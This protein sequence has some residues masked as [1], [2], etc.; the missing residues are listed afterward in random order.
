MLEVRYR[1]QRLL[2]LEWLQKFI[3]NRKEKEKIQEKLK[4]AYKF[5]EMKNCIGKWSIFLPITSWWV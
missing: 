2:E 5:K 3:N 1:I 4:E